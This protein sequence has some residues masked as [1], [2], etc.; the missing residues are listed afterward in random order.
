MQGASRA[1]HLEFARVTEKPLSEPLPN[2][3]E[4]A[5]VYTKALIHFV[6]FGEDAFSAATIF[7]RYAP[8][9]P[10]TISALI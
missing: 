4:D 10:I 8:S 6:G 7:S 3:S 5:R 2:T 1:M 9:F